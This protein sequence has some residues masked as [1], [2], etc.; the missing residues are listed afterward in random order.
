MKRINHT[1]RLARKIEPL[2]R[3]QFKHA[4]ATYKR[5]MAQRPW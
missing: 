4:L 1:H 2:L 5:V 3:L